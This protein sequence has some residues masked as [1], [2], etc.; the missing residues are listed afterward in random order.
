MAALASLSRGRV[1]QPLSGQGGSLGLYGFSPMELA[2]LVARAAGVP[3][4]CSVPGPTESAAGMKGSHEAAF[5]AASAVLNITCRVPGSRLAR[6][7]GCLHST[8]SLAITAISSS[9]VW[10]E[11]SVK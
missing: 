9:L 8:S 4:Y 7:G 2:H 11:P 1:R 10:R 6:L 5:E 3:T